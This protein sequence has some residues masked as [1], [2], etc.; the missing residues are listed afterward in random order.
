VTAALPPDPA[1][2]LT[3]LEE[4]HQAAVSRAD[5]P[6]RPWLEQN[7]DEP[8]EIEA[9][10]SDGARMV[11]GECFEEATVAAIVAE[12]NAFPDLLAAVRGVLALADEAERLYRAVRTDRIR[13]AVAAALGETGGGK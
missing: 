3:R 12:H 10:W 6:S 13:A 8:Q 9:V 11:I 7:A 5:Y 1:E 4:L 2:V